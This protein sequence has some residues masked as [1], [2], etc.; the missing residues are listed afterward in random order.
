MADGHDRQRSKT[1]SITPPGLSG[2]SWATYASVTIPTPGNGDPPNATITAAHSAG[3]PRSGRSWLHSGC[4]A[5]H[6]PTQE[7]GETGRRST[8]PPRYLTYGGIEELARETLGSLFFLQC[9]GMKKAKARLGTMEVGTGSRLLVPYLAWRGTRSSRQ[10][11]ASHGHRRQQCRG[12]ERPSLAHRT[13]W[14]RGGASPVLF[15]RREYSGAR[16]SSNDYPAAEGSLWRGWFG[17]TA[18]IV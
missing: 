6:I 7:F 3:C 4:W 9:G 17:E 11:T 2:L 16:G 14:N 10:Q 15:Q 12:E 1:A 8:S 5:T 13:T 18:N